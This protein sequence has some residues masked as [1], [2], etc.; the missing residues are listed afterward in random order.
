M[1]PDPPRLDDPNLALD[2][3]TGKHQD[4]LAREGSQGADTD[5]SARPE[6]GNT[7]GWLRRKPQDVA[8]IQVQGDQTASLQATDLIEH[9]IG[10]SLKLL[11]ADSLDVVASVEED[12]ASADTEVLVKL[13]VHAAGPTWIST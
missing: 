5:P 8:E 13:D 7:S 4:K 1:D 10:T 3:S 12:L 11:I 9:F 2:R 6:D